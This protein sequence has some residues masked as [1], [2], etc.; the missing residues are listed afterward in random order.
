MSAAQDTLD[1]GVA[2]RL[3]TLDR[4]LPV[5]IGAA[6]V[7]GLLAG[8]WI[9]GLDV[10]LESIQLDGISLPIALGL[11]IMM[12]PVLAKVRY[13]RLDTVT[14]D[15]RLLVS[16]LVLNW[17]LGPA[18][19][20]ALAWL[21]LP[22]LPEYRTGLIIVGLARCIAMVVIW[23]DLACGDREAA[24]VLVAL[25]SVFQVI[26]FAGLGWFYLDVLPGWLGLSQ[27]GLDVSPWQ[28]ARSVLIFLGIPLVAGYLTRRLGERAKG[29]QWYESRFLPRIGPWALYGLLFTIVMLFALQG[30][31]ITS[32]P[33]DVVRIA[34][35]LLVY[36][37]VMWAGSFLMGKAVGLG[38]ARAT[39]L[40]FTA[41]G[42]NFELAIAVA[43]A[44][45]GVTSGQALAGVVGPLIEV[46]V[47]VGLVYVSLW[48][49]RFFPAA[50]DPEPDDS[51]TKDAHDS[52][53]RTT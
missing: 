6:M 21:M 3:S 31:Q 10:A 24:A 14:G 35:P 20:F 18:L 41:A 7:L 49:R 2:S 38:Y 48:A 4:L 36:F 17:V 39:T 23:N 27:D 1:G 44:T 30:E 25:N 52:A 9:P 32:R 19:M 47:L 28:I 46:P 40:A 51:S 15:R 42:N 12:Y 53:T 8:R 13:D 22:D 33:W 50:G 45:Y 37:A 16:S 26:A 5:W 43:V 11:L 29:R 34:L